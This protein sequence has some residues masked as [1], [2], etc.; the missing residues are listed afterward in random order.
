MAIYNQNTNF[1]NEERYLKNLMMTS[2]NIK[3]ANWAKNELSKLYETAGLSGQAKDWGVGAE[4]R[5]AAD[6]AGRDK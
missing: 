6:K 3:E 5:T 1:S 2:D 4:S